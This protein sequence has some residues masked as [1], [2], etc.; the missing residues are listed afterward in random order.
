MD[1]RPV[2]GDGAPSAGGGSPL[3]SALAVVLAWRRVIIAVT[4]GF[5]LVAL[6]YS[7]LAKPTYVVR[8]SL[9]PKQEESGVMGLSSLV[10]NQFGALAG[11]LSGITSDSDVLVTILE[12]DEIRDRI[13]E[14]LDL[15]RALRIKAKTPERARELAQQRLQKLV[16]VDLTRRSSIFLEV[17]APTAVLAADIANG[18][19]EELDRMNR[20]FAFTSAKQTRIF[21]EQRLAET[22]DSLSAGQIRLENFQRE[23]GMV[24]LDEQAKAEVEVVAKLEAELIGMEAQL[25]VQRQYSTRAFSKTRELEHRIGALRTRLGHIATGAPEGDSGDDRL[26][27]SFNRLPSLGR[28]LADLMLGI[29]THQAVF[30]LL[31]TQYQQARIDEARDIPTIQVLDK[32]RPPATRDTPRRKKNVMVGLATGLGLGLALAFGLEYLH[33]TLGAIPGASPEVRRQVGPLLSRVVERLE[34][35]R[36]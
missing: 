16:S 15:V 28:Q 18:Y 26:L 6:V 29:K 3:L 22:R 21:I 20:E 14:R 2:P 8:S 10:A 5:V 30:T 23:H 13:I 32:A 25:E 17:R 7:I 35:L 31:T 36:S 34:A 4:A 24:A 9:L 1:T 19:F 12:S 11:G 33:R 27:I